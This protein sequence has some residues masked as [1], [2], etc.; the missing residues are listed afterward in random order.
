[1][2]EKIYQVI[3]VG[4]EAKHLIVKH[5]LQQALTKIRYSKSIK[6]IPLEL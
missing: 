3:T 2:E 1:M 6:I 5:Q 4:I